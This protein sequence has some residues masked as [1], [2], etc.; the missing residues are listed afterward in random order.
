MRVST[1]GRSCSEEE[2]KKSATVS[3]NR[4]CARFSK[5]RELNA[6]A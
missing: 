1:S 2:K 3:P 4:G 6:R 5:P